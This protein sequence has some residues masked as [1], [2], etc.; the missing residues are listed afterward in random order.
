MIDFG[1]LKNLNK[2]VTSNQKKHA[3]AEN[4]INKLSEKVKLLSTKKYKLFRQNILYKR[5]RITKYDC[6]PTNI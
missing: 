3:L 6:L 4:E 2:K 1:N 5:W